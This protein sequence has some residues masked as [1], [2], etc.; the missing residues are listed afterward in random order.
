MS[1]YSLSSKKLFK[2]KAAFNL[3]ILVAVLATAA[4]G[5][6]WFTRSKLAT[7]EQKEH[8]ELARLRKEFERISN[9]FPQPEFSEITDQI[10]SRFKM[11]YNKPEDGLKKPALVFVLNSLPGTGKTYYAQQIARAL[12]IENQ[13]SYHVY[14]MRP[15]DHYLNFEKIQEFAATNASIQ[16]IKENRAIQPA[17]LLY[18]EYTHAAT[19]A[20]TNKDTL[21]E[22]I[23]ELKKKIQDAEFAT[24]AARLKEKV[25]SIRRQN[26]FTSL[27]TPQSQAAPEP[28][29]DWEAVVEELDTSANKY[30]SMYQEAA[31]ELRQISDE[32]N[33]IDEA[34]AK[35]LSDKSNENLQILWYALGT[36]VLPKKNLRNN[37][38]LGEVLQRTARNINPIIKSKTIKYIERVIKDAERRKWNKELA[39]I[40]DQKLKSQ[41]KPQPSSF[42]P[43]P[44][45]YGGGGGGF[46]SVS[47][48]S[49]GSAPAKSDREEIILDKIKAVDQQIDRIDI[50]L[51]SIENDIDNNV[52]NIKHIMVSLVQ[53]YGP[54]VVEDVAKGLG[55][56]DTDAVYNREFTVKVAQLAAYS[57]LT[58]PED[59]ENVTASLKTL[60]AELLR[61]NKTGGP[62]DIL[63]T[64]FKEEPNTFYSVY[65]Q[66]LAT[67]PADEDRLTGNIVIFL[68]GNV[69]SLQEKVIA[70]VIATGESACQAPADSGAP[71]LP[72]YRDPDCLRKITEKI[73][74]E[75]ESTKEMEDTLARVLG[76]KSPVK[77][78]GS[79]MD[80]NALAFKSRIGNIRFILP[81]TSS[82]YRGFLTR[83]LDDVKSEFSRSTGINLVFTD[84]I[85]NSF[86]FPKFVNSQLGFRN[87]VDRARH[88]FDLVLDTKVRSVIARV[89]TARPTA[90]GRVTNATCDVKDIVGRIGDKKVE[91]F[92]IPKKPVH[93]VRVDFEPGSRPANGQLVFS[94]L[95]KDRGVT[96]PVQTTWFKVKEETPIEA[97]D[98]DRKLNSSQR[99][100]YARYIAAIYGSMGLIAA[101]L[102]T[103][104]VSLKN[105]F[106]AVPNAA[107]GTS[108]TEVNLSIYRSNLQYYSI[109]IQAS[110][111]AIAAFFSIDRLERPP[112]ELVLRATSTKV[113]IDDLWDK[114]RYTM[115][116]IGLDM[117]YLFARDAKNDTSGKPVSESD[118][119]FREFVR[120]HNANPGKKRLDDDDKEAVYNAV[121]E[122]FIRLYEDNQTYL[123]AIE[124]IASTVQSELDTLAASPD[125]TAEVTAEEIE[126]II[127]KNVG[128]KFV[129]EP[130]THGTIRCDAQRQAYGKV[131]FNIGLGEPLTDTNSIVAENFLRRI[132]DRSASDLGRI[133]RVLRRTDRQADITND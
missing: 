84:R 10:Y 92:T 38:G 81:P 6:R 8:P 7:S 114:V 14:E 13:E 20:G 80:S 23:Q 90:A 40:E 54:S 104:P 131:D 122:H 2:T 75:P 21:Q 18:D 103:I 93:E 132:L 108:P 65:Q 26:R 35:S 85:L 116:R 89:G 79:P 16:S 27:A 71:A 82:D 62:E 19:L 124:A 4:T 55:I 58:S 74:S 102:P 113:M 133:T 126:K 3:W 33:N 56:A 37:S 29:I 48:P 34:A 121:L 70:N 42:R 86:L 128:I 95:T 118:A 59:V 88:Q 57:G 109:E 1:R 115:D 30:S 83:Q 119:I 127:R 67:R 112:P 101:S 78:D 36:G 72:F 76:K 17:V 11:I 53:A 91:T 41:Q 25:T 98:Q 117:D 96:E 94:G 106:G 31:R 69:L 9:L 51:A 47:S 77:D 32:K 12:N 61:I 87:L 46:S 73:L 22:Q 63:L 45:G 39:D 24:V 110:I 60:Q 28:Q 50:E 111:G 125:A 52:N 120:I 68:A 99:I 49:G 107:K 66:T 97:E 43:P 130:G 5:C 100:A 105:S 129:T 44:G 64:L 123:D 15:S